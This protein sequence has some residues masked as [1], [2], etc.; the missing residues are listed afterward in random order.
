MTGFM[1]LAHNFKWTSTPNFRRCYWVPLFY[2]SLSRDWR[3]TQL[4]LKVPVTK[5]KMYCKH[6]K[7]HQYLPIARAG[8][9]T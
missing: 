2:L 3:V 8:V 1:F 7:I 9:Q 4:A 5:Y 6:W